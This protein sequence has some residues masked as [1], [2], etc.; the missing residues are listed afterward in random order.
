M[1]QLYKIYDD[2]LSRISDDMYMELTP[3]QTMGMLFKL[4][5]Q[6]I[7]WFEFPR[8]S[9]EFVEENTGEI[10]I[11]TSDH[12]ANEDQLC[13]EGDLTIEEIGII[14]TYMVV[15]WLGQ[16]LAN[17]DLVRQHYTGADFKLTSQASHLQRVSKLK[18]DYEDQGFH[19]QRLYSRRKKEDG[20]IKSTMG[21]IMESSTGGFNEVKTRYT[22]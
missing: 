12:P 6:A 19:L 18:K 4:L 21:M 3:E 15:A 2:F 13:I 9:L 7:P 8:T 22:D 1:T 20:Q 10:V 5:R 14:A 17:I 16:Q 11:V